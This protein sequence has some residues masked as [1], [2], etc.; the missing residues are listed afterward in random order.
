MNDGQTTHYKNERPC[1]SCGRADASEATCMCYKY[2]Q[3]FA[4]EWR[5]VCKPFREAQA[6]RGGLKVAN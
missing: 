6:K 2:R 4:M 5:S 3:W 1:E